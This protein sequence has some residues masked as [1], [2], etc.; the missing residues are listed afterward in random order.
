MKSF[1]QIKFNQPEDLIFMDSPNNELFTLIIKEKTYHNDTMVL[2][3]DLYK[4]KK[5]T[6][7]WEV[8]KQNENVT[9]SVDMF[10]CGALFFRKEQAKEHFKIRI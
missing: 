10:N 2:I 1:P 3:R 5:N 7:D 8:F 4:N 6:Q 9:V